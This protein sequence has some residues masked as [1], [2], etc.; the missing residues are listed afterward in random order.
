MLLV[1]YSCNQL[2]IFFLEIKGIIDDNF[3]LLTGQVLECSLAKPQADQKSYGGSGSQNSTLNSSF[4][5][6][7]GYSL[8]GGAYGGLGTGFGPAGFGQVMLFLFFPPDCRF[9]MLIYCFGG[10]GK[11]NSLTIF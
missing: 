8:V 1:P 11:G 7:L 10:V 9:F 2:P 5:P 6:P 4:P 3:L